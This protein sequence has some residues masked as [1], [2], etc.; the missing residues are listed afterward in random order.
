MPPPAARIAEVPGGPPAE[1]DMAG[2]A[3]RGIDG[4]V[5]LS[6]IESPGLAAALALAEDVRVPTGVRDDGGMNGVRTNTRSERRRWQGVAMIGVAAIAAWVQPAAAQSKAAPAAAASAAPAS[7]SAPAPEVGCTTPLD[8]CTRERI[9]LLNALARRLTAASRQRPA[10]SLPAAER[11]RLAQYDRW[12][13]AQA[14]RARELAERGG[15]A[16]TREIQLG[17]NQQYLELQRQMQREHRG[18]QSISDIMKS[19]HDAAT[20]AIGSLR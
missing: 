4:L 15:A 13:Q 8:L 12:L 19:K 3:A 11:D 18:F 10:A 20:H 6:G 16:T 14:R 7:Q 9:D 5:C 1:A 2:P 17:F